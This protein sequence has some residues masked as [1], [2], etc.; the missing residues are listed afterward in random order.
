MIVILTLCLLVV[1]VA[2]MVICTPMDEDCLAAN[3]IVKAWAIGIIIG[4]IVGILQI[5]GGK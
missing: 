1:L 4:V 3:P 2:L 5:I